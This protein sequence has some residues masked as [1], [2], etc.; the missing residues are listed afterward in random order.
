[1][2]KY[3]IK[4]N[5]EAVDMPLGASN[6]LERFNPFFDFD[7]IRG[8]KMMD[9]TVPFSPKTDR[10][11][12]W[13]GNHQSSLNQVK[14]LCEKYANGQMIERGFGHLSDVTT[15][16]YKVFFSSSLGDFFGKYQTLP[17]PLIDFGSEALENL[18]TQRG[19]NPL[20]DKVAFPVV[21]NPSFYGTNVVSG[22]NGLVNEVGN[23]DAP[24]VP[25]VGLPF[26]LR[27]IEELTNVQ[28]TGDFFETNWY[29]NGIVENTFSLD[30]QQAISYQNHLPG[31]T[32]PDFLKELGKLLNYG[33]Y[34]DPTRRIVRLNNRNGILR[35]ATT[36]NLTNRVV[37]SPARMPKAG[38]R[39][40]L[41]WALDSNDALMKVV[42]Q[43]Y[44]KYQATG[45][46]EDTFFEI[47]SQFSTR[48]T[49]NGIAAADQVGISDKIANG[50]ANFT[51]KLLFWNGIIADKATATHTCDTVL[52]V[53]NIAA[54]AYAGLESWLKKT[55]SREL[56]ARLDA[57]LLAE[58]DF[59]STGG[60]NSLVHIYG[61]NYIIESIRINLPIE[62]YATMTVWEC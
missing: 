5:G 6:T 56:Y 43:E 61:R 30:G 45:R 59:A 57:V 51:P 35:Q 25:M 42:P 31:L 4:L 50:S 20:M 49:A 36:I 8:S 48:L 28:F 27:K 44:V 14:Y 52:S 26:L 60:K 37:P 11:F 40:A 41:N 3:Y 62:G 21:A 1:M 32:I 19:Y 47:N 53:A 34:I 12:N 58:L 17:M 33:I 39:L 29:R 2:R 22:F 55:S 18:E 9:F 7:T 15:E 38:N 10:L 23:A 13:Y 16:G 54:T 46:E 24:V